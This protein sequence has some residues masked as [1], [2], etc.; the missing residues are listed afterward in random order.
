[1]RASWWFVS[2]MFFDGL[3]AGEDPEAPKEDRVVWIVP[4]VEGVR[5]EGTALPSSNAGSGTVRRNIP[6]AWLQ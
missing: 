6:D 2:W 1:M 4:G 5:G 3:A